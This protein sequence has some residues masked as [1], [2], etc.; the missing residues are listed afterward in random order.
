M[1]SSWFHLNSAHFR[2]I[3]FSFSYDV[4]IRSRRKRSS[5]LFSLS[6]IFYQFTARAKQTQTRVIRAKIEKKKQQK[7]KNDCQWKDWKNEREEERNTNVEAFTKDWFQFI[8]CK[9]DVSHGIIYGKVNCVN[10]SIISSL[11]SYK[12]NDRS[13]SKRQESNES[14]FASLL[15]GRWNL[16]FLRRTGNVQDC[17]DKILCL[18]W[19][20][21][22]FVKSNEIYW[23]LDEEQ[24]Q[25]RLKQREAK[26]KRK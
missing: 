14:F 15:F 6:D 2:Y 13:K 18:L 10:I 5:L 17:A 20:I 19:H 3:F 1:F 12:Q 16:F 9:L 11:L 22:F 26:S 4:S 8:C 23:Q 24:R 7:K 21:E 25:K